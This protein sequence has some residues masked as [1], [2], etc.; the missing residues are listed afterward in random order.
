MN[1]EIN[2]SLNGAHFFATAERSITSEPRALEVF[3]TLRE[4]FPEAHG[5][6]VTASLMQHS[7]RN[8]TEALAGK[9]AIAA[10]KSK[11]Q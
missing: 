8:V 10:R 2:V 6:T 9:L 7:G 4:K 11:A 3:K 5:W 1:Y